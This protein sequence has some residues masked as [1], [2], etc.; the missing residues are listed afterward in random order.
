MAGKDRRP[1]QR[2][3]HQGFLDQWLVEADQEKWLR[4]YDANL[5]SFRRQ[6][7][8]PRPDQE[9]QPLQRDLVKSWPLR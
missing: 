2:V 9:R 8:R 3:R 7:P 4:D 6:L 1:Q 5:Q